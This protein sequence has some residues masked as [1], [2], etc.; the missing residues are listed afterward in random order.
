[1][2]ELQPVDIV[3]L[4]ILGIACLRGLFLGLIREAFSIGAL[5]AAVV[6]VRLFLDPVSAWLIDTTGGQIG[7]TIAPWVAGALL[8]VGAIAGVGLVGRVLQKGARAVGLG[9]A[10]R[11]GGAA[12][13]LA[14]GVIAAGVLLLVS[15][16]VLGRSHEFLAGSR[17]LGAL[18]QLEQIAA[19]NDLDTTIDVAA[20]PLPLPGR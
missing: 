1:M 2:G 11:A 9:W 17:S 18:E 13:G 12:L 15:S 16:A 3:A 20:P 5:A 6:V 4:A 7:E 14:E 10:D 8:A 19:E